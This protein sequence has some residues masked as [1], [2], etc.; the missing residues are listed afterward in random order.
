MNN[1]TKQNYTVVKEDCLKWLK[2]LEG[3]IK[4]IHIDA[5]HEY[6]SVI[7]TI[8]LVLPKMV[9]GGIICG[10]DYQSANINR[11]DLHGEVERAVREALP[12]HKSIVNLWYYIHQ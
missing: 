5:S 4:F 1:N 7:E 3:N 9:K 11:H 10:D 2:T 8:N 6:E 12:N